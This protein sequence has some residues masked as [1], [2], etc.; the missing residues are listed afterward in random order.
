M[1]LSKRRYYFWFITEKFLI[2]FFNLLL[3]CER[4]K[5]IMAPIR[6]QPTM[7]EKGNAVLLYQQGNSIRQI[8][9]Q[10]KISRS[11]V[12][13]I[14]QRHKNQ[15]PLENKPKTGRKKKLTEKDVAYLARMV[16][17]DPFVSAPK[18]AK[19]M[20]ETTGK[21]MGRMTI[22]RALKT[23]GIGSY[24]PCK[25]PFISK[26]N[27]AKRL[28]Y[29]KKYQFMDVSFWKKVIWTDESKFNVRGSDGRERVWRK[30]GESLKLKNMRGTV[31]H[32]GGSEMVWGAMCYNGVG[33]MEFVDGIMRKE[34][35]KMIL[36]RNLHKTTKQF[37]MG[38]NYIFMHDNDPKHKSKLVTEYLQEK[39]VNVLD[40][41]AQS[42]DLNVIEHL[43]DEIGRA[44]LVKDIR[45]KTDLR[46]EICTAWETLSS[47]VT[48]KLVE[49]MPRRLK[50]VILHKG[51]PTSY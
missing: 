27:R 38:R 42:P 10:L 12:D 37:R 51:G 13:R 46:R 34:D 3:L 39:G 25:K 4:D 7:C 19:R 43:W 21:A 30:S 31:K 22:T 36:E 23:S 24:V 35:Y 8:S 45:N 1:H 18:L 32:G 15:E 40:H 41:P 26:K 20:E 9:D 48:K 47:D 33:S 16:R 29:A 14:I 5:Y 17:K 11:T 49:S 50:E 6:K 44:L 28:E 2:N